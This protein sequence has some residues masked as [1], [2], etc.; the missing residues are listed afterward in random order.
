M[1]TECTVC[2]TFQIKFG[3]LVVTEPP[4]YSVCNLDIQRFTQCQRYY[5]YLDVRSRTR[6]HIVETFHWCKNLAKM[7]PD[8]SEEILAVLIFTE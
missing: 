1:N 3:Y 8:S 2:G 6:Y 7:L 4:A 5:T